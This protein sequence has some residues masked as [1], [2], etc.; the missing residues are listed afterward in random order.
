MAGLPW[1]VGGGNAKSGVVSDEVK[2]LVHNFNNAKRKRIPTDTAEVDAMFK[3]ALRMTLA[4]RNIVDNE[5]G[6][7][8]AAIVVQLNNGDHNSKKHKPGFI[9]NLTTIFPSYLAKVR[10][11]EAKLFAAHASLAGASPSVLKAD[12]VQKCCTGF[13]WGCCGFEVKVKQKAKLKL[14]SRFLIISPET[15]ATIDC[16]KFAVVKTWPLKALRRFAAPPSAITLDFGDDTEGYCT[17]QTPE[18]EIIS[19]MLAGL[20]HVCHSEAQKQTKTSRSPEKKRWSSVD[21]AQQSLSSSPKRWSS[22]GISS[23]GTKESSSSPGKSRSPTK[24]RRASNTA[25]SIAINSKFLQE[26][27]RVKSSL[28]ALKSTLAEPASLP[29]PASDPSWRTKTAAHCR[30]TIEEFCSSVSSG[31]AIVLVLCTSPPGN[32][33]SLDK[34]AV[35]GPLEKI[36]TAL[37]SISSAVRMVSA[38]ADTMALTQNILMCGRGLCDAIAEVLKALGASASST[39]ADSALHPACEQYGEQV[40][41]FLE[42]IFTSG[43]ELGGDLKV[44]ANMIAFFRQRAESVLTGSE[45]AANSGRSIGNVCVDPVIKAELFLCMEATIIAGKQLVVCTSICAATVNHKPCAS[46]VSRNIELIS[47]LLQAF[48]KSATRACKDA[49]I[50]SHFKGEIALAASE[51]SQFNE[52]IASA[53]NPSKSKTSKY[54]KVCEDIAAATKSMPKLYG[55]AAELVKHSTTIAR[56]ASVLVGLIKEDATA[57]KD[58]GKQKKLNWAARTI[59]DATSRIVSAAKSCARNA[60]DITLQKKLLRAGQAMG[61]LALY[62]KNLS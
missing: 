23:T 9:D 8:L 1:R 38:L 37:N 31:M 10:G 17:F 30:G 46:E 24:G 21:E 29:P 5:L 15:V 43:D 60:K 55:D 41:Q 26:M 32:S 35:L 40:T 54:K 57:E 4:G 50:L 61:G 19:T 39:K 27:G 22:A 18:S 49:S 34:Q 62:C 42:Y 11:I 53:F 7:Q 28:D 51:V 25:V 47:T 45:A 13:F 58:I 48:E 3:D 33:W 20:M 36:S 52:A 14:V 2:Q 56:H 59:T 6:V 16:E 12:F 44:T